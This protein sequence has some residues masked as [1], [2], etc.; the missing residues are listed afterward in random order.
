[1]PNPAK[2]SPIQQMAAICLRWLLDP[3][4]ELVLAPNEI[5][6]LQ[7]LSGVDMT[8]SD[9]TGFGRKLR[10][11]KR[12]REEHLPLARRWTQR[13]PN[14]TPPDDRQ[15]NDFIHQFLGLVDHEIFFEQG[16]TASTTHQRRDEPSA[17]QL[18]FSG[19]MPC[20]TLHL[21]T[22]G[23]GLYLSDHCEIEAEPGQLML[24]HPEARYHYG[25]APAAEKWTHH[26]VLFQPRSHWSE[27]MD[28]IPADEGIL[29]LTLPDATSLAQLDALLTDLISIK[30]NAVTHRSELEHNRLEE[31]LIRSHSLQRQS[32][33]QTVDGRIA[34]A[35]EYMEKKIA[36]RFNVDEVASVCNLSGSR[37]AHLFKQHMGISPKAWS[38]NL[39]LQLARKHL[40]NGDESIGSIANS[41][42][43]EDPTQFTRNFKKNVG[44]SPREFRSSFGNQV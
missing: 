33:H 34:R 13:W 17:S 18:D 22:E 39:R 29:Q 5:E 38:N 42:G 27:W 15:A 43:Y 3:K 41:L 11:S 19:G 26:W 1:M 35:C 44:C 36:A 31:I 14:G 9:L 7:A 28:W 2:Y 8:T 12:F 30:S 37:F 20:W 25:L 6:P 24:F 21:T 32:S 4:H 40:L 10:D 16:I 23:S